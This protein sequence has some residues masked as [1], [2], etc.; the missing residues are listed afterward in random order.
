MFIGEAVGRYDC[1]TYLVGPDLKAW[2]S[3]LTREATLEEQVEY[4]KSRA[5]A[6]D[7]PA[8]DTRDT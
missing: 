1:P 2:A 7:S 4:W 8:S 6:I 5:L 3:D